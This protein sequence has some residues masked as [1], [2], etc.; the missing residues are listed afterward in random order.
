MSTTRILASSAMSGE[1]LDQ[2]GVWDV[3][4]RLIGA[5]RRDLIQLTRGGAVG[6]AKCLLTAGA[7]FVV[8]LVDALGGTATDELGDEAGFAGQV[9]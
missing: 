2:A 8:E 4:K 1:H 9:R 5:L 3:D 7:L 6:S